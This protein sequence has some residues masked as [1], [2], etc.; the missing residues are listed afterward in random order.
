MNQ[1]EEYLKR[2]GDAKKK[3][4][5]KNVN[6]LDEGVPVIIDHPS[7]E[8]QLTDEIYSDNGNAQPDLIPTKE[9]PELEELPAYHPSPK[10]R[11]KKFRKKIYKHIHIHTHVHTQIEKVIFYGMYTFETNII[12]AIYTLPFAQY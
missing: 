3:K 9:Q 2:L 4:I 7:P 1:F 10:P 6:L 8:Q 11:K 12:L 5:L